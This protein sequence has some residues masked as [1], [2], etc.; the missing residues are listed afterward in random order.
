MDQVQ[1]QFYNQGFRWFLDWDNSTSLPSES[2]NS[3]VSQIA[4]WAYFFQQANVTTKLFVGISNAGDASAMIRGNN[5]YT[6]IN[7]RQNFPNATT[8]GNA[9][10]VGIQIKQAILD[11]MVALNLTSLEWFGG[12]MV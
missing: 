12:I 2:Y 1:V 10:Y 5:F 3:F 8:A 4:Q 6:S 7:A 9:A 11:T